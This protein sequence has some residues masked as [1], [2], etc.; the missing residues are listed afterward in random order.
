MHPWVLT[1]RAAD[2][3]FLTI[4]N[5]LLPYKR[6]S[7][8]KNQARI[9]LHNQ[10][11]M[12]QLYIIMSD[13]CKATLSCSRVSLNLWIGTTVHN[14]GNAERIHPCIKFSI[15]DTL[16]TAQLYLLDC[17]TS[18]QRRHC[19]TARLSIKQRDPFFSLISFYF[20][21]IKGVAFCHWIL[22]T[23]CRCYSAR[24]VLQ[25]LTTAKLT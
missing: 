14:I 25:P 21:R 16:E 10:E 17:R 7:M 18:E 6:L 13:L 2:S 4:N 12:E 5:P 3:C 11:H 19:T 24:L 22:L 20:E 8:T 23:L 15:L 1:V 9:P